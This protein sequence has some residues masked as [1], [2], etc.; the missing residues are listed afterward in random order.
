[1]IHAPETMP[2][3]SL[4]S[5]IADIKSLDH[6]LIERAYEFGAKAHAGQKRKSGDDF[7]WH[8]IEVV[9]ILVDLNLYDTVTIASAL[10]HDVIEDTACPLQ[11]IRRNFG[12]ERAGKDVRLA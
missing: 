11:E 6:A 2:K 12:D 9:R 4:I 7:I 5:F 10:I 3:V 8:A 1:M